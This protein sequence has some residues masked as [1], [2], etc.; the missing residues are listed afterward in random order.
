M[1]EKTNLGGKKNGLSMEVEKCTFGVM[2]F[3]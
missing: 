3:F 2:K 1:E